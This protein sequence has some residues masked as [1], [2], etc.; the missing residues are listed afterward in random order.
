MGAFSIFHWV[1][2]AVVG[3]IVLAAPIAVIVAIVLIVRN[4]G[5]P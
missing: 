3:A 2:F 1:L 5:K 4:N